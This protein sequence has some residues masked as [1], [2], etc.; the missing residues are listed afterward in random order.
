MF[1][2]PRD[3]FLEADTDYKTFLISATSCKEFKGRENED[4]QVYNVV[5][6]KN[7]VYETKDR[8]YYMGTV[9]GPNGGISTRQMLA[10]FGD[11]ISIDDEIKKMEEKYREVFN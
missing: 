9:V 10:T 8:I 3:V 2:I 5:V 7:Q 11:T 6:A 4:W 1:E